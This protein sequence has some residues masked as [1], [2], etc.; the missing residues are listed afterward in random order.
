MGGSGQRISAGLIVML[1]ALTGPT[2][3]LAGAS[4]SDAEA[5]AMGDV[6][7]R[8]SSCVSRPKRIKVTPGQSIQAAIAKAQPGTVIGVA[9][10][11]YRE[12][13]DLTGLQGTPDKPIIL[14]SADGVGAATILGAPEK[15]AIAAWGIANVGIYGFRVVA[16]TSD[17]DMGAFK[18]AGPWEKPARNVAVVG[19]IVTGVGTDGIKFFNGATNI[20]VVGNVI[21]GDWREE[22]MDNVSI[23]NALFAYNTVRGSARNTSITMKAGSRN[24]ILTGNDFNSRSNVGI[25]VGGVGT[26]RFNRK[27]PDYWK[28]FEATSITVAGNVVGDQ[29]RKSVSFIGANN[30]VLKENFLSNGVRSRQ[31]EQPGELLYPSHDNR[32][33]DNTVRS[34]DFFEP[35][36]GQDKG[37]VLSRNAPGKPKIQAGVLA[38]PKSGGAICPA[39]PPVG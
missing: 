3:G 23:E 28:G 15:P 36:D 22:A 10:G 9:A 29:A 18:I 4:V 32:I 39:T 5:V 21:D 24:I 6:V 38:F 16:D 27:F 17:G 14:M 25:N 11:V 7:A 13:L 1:M 34:T 12:A 20:L 8:A 31:H 19:N 30:S 2:S 33:Q 26:S 35:D 37:Y